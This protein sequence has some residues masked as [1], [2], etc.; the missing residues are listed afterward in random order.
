M[1]I[2]LSALAWAGAQGDYEAGIAAMRAGDHDAAA[3]RFVS[4]LEAGGRDPAVY[5]GLGNALYR[6]DRLG[7]AIAAWERGLALAPGNGDIS[8]NLERARKQTIDRLDPPKRSYGP[9]FWQALLPART[10]ALLA[11]LLITAG[12]SVLVLAQLRA[13]RV[14]RRGA[15]VALLLGAL[16]AISTVVASRAA[17]EAVVVQPQVS[18]R[19]ALGPDGVELFVLHEGAR[20]SVR[21][22]AGDDILI[23]LP[24]NR[25]GWVSASALLSAD[26]AAPF[27]LRARGG[28]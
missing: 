21:E 19:S 17:P 25:R 13:A 18:A 2:V 3:A 14:L 5:H 27:P 1:I 4:A 6:S 20:V 15:A 8:A 22:D 9:F 24:D 7:E 10:T 11:S 12:L 26:P 16:L 28:L 23:A